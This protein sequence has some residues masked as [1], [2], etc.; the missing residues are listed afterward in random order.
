MEK[1]TAASEEKQNLYSKFFINLLQFFKQFMSKNR[2][3][4]PFSEQ[5]LK[6]MFTKKQRT[7][8]I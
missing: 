6:V 1:K 7:K 4:K 5:N 3:K 8:M 2:F